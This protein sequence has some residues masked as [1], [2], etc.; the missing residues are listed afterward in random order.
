MGIRGLLSFILEARDQC[1]NYQDLVNIARERNGIEILVDYYSF[2]QYLVERFWQGMEKHCTNEFL[3]LYGGEYKSLDRF[4]TKLVT[5]LKSLDIHLVMYVDGAKG[6]SRSATEQKFETWKSRHRNDIERMHYLIDVC[7]GRRQ[8]QDLPD[9]TN[10]R[11]VCQEIQM[12]DTLKQ[13]G[14]EIVQCTYGEAD[15]VIARA[16]QVRPKAYVV[17]SN[18]TDFAL[19]RDCMFIPYELF[20]VHGDLTLGEGAYTEKPIRLEVGVVSTTSVGPALR[21]GTDH[22]ALVEFS[23]IAGNDFTSHFT[24]SLVHQIGLNRHPKVLDYA[25]WIVKHRNVQNHPA[26]AKLMQNSRAFSDAVKRTRQFYTLNFHEEIPPSSEQTSHIDEHIKNG[27]FPPAIMAMHCCFYWHRQLLEDCSRGHPTVEIALSGFRE[28]LYRLLLERNMQFSMEHGRTPMTEFASAKVFKSRAPG[29]PLVHH[30]S[31]DKVFSSLK[32]FH[33]ILTSL[34]P[35]D[36][37]IDFF[38]RYGRKNGFVCYVLRYFLML[39]VG[40]NLNVTFDELLALIAMT[41]SRGRYEDTYQ[42]IAVRPSIRAITLGNWFQDIYRHAYDFLAKVLFLS[43]EFCKPREIFSG[44]TWLAFYTV[45][46]TPNSGGLTH[47][48]VHTVRNDYKFQLKDKQHM[49]KFIM[50]GVF[51]FNFRM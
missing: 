7:N 1:V 27:N 42:C 13:C 41:F 50:Q 45:T 5:D 29:I 12:Y 23:I 3:K 40:R 39:N 47:E 10:I 15:F 36:Y 46:C 18:D 31:P 26:V 30:V 8:I 28:F 22:S 38:H 43:H 11:P 2:Q 49:I 16:L 4:V 33:R 21:L 14:V 51:D 24:R 20:D 6:S 25:Q 19:M 17:L 37:N 34:E 48:K 9:R 35:P 44:S 32:L